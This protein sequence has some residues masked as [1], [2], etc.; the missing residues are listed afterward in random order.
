MQ[1]YPLTDLPT[2][3]LEA[4]FEDTGYRE[5]YEAARSARIPAKRGKN[6]RWTFVADDLPVIAERLNLLVPRSAA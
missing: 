4:G 3:L 1:T 2:A 6:G 5:I